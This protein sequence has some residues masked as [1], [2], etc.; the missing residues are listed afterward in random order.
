MGACSSTVQKGSCP[1]P[2]LSMSVH[3]EAEPCFP[4]LHSTVAGTLSPL[5]SPGL[6][7]VASYFLCL[8]VY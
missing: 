5:K 3:G 7:P 2:F 1:D 6:L 8:W 4:A